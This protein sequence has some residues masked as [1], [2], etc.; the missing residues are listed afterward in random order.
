MFQVYFQTWNNAQVLLV[1]ICCMLPHLVKNLKMFQHYTLEML[2]KGC[3]KKTLLV[4]RNEHYFMYV[5]VYDFIIHSILASLDWLQS[6]R[7]KLDPQS[8]SP[9]KDP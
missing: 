1:Y 4:L 9:L 8:K 2:Y 7:L 3:V 6:H 5:L